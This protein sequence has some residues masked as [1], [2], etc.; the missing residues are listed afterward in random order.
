MWRPFFQ[1]RLKCPSHGDASAEIYPSFCQLQ[2][3]KKTLT[4]TLAK[5][6]EGTESE[7]ETEKYEYGDVKVQKY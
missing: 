4:L 2:T 7:K 3:F 1:F 5:N 6:T